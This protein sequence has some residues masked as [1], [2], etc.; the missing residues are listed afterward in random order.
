MLQA[1][2]K[3]LPEHP[4]AKDWKEVA[5]CSGAWLENA[6]ELEDKRTPTQGVKLFGQKDVFARLQREGS[7][8]LQIAG[9]TRRKS[10]DWVG[11][12]VLMAA[13]G[14]CSVQLSSPLWRSHT[15]ALS[16]VIS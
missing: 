2:M 16:R 4:E 6:G 1:N 7:N 11:L 13:S 8:R 14:D 15:E 12:I 9:G 5:E 10:E 3:A